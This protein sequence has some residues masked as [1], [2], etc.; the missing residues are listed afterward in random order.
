MLDTVEDLV[1]FAGVAPDRHDRDTRDTLGGT[2]N[3]RDPVLFN[4]GRFAS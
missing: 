4:R 3:R 2:K 1:R